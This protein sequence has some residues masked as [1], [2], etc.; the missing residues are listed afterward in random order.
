MLEKAEQYDAL[1]VEA[2][3]MRE[4]SAGLR[5]ALEKLNGTLAVLQTADE[6]QKHQISDLKRLAEIRKADLDYLQLE[7]KDLR[8]K[9]DE[10]DRA[11]EASERRAVILES[12]V[13]C[14]IILDNFM[15]SDAQKRTNRHP[16]WRI[17]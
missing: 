5:G 1:S 2:S 12:K 14:V 7:V 11:A 10:K 13:P 3:R 8:H 17:N 16:S 9:C 4:E 6:D 15:L